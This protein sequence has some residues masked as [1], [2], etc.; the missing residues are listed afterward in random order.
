MLVDEEQIADGMRWAAEV[1]HLIVE[2]SAALG[3][4][5]LRARLGRLDGRRVA[6]VITGRNVDTGIFRA[7]LDQ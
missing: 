3:V 7:V 5:A 6:V 2:G 1:H 4:A